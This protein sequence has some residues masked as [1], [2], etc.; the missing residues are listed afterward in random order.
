[1]MGASPSYITDSAAAAF[2]FPPRRSM[3]ENTG[4]NAAAFFL[5]KP[6]ASDFV[7][8]YTAPPTTSGRLVWQL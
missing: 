5:K 2:R 8:A 6:I 4:S 1:M 3:Q 7:Y